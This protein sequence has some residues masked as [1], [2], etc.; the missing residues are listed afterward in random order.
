[1]RHITNIS[2][3]FLL[4]LTSTCNTGI[5]EHGT[6]KLICIS[7]PLG[8]N[9]LF[10][11]AVTS[12]I[13]NIQVCQIWTWSILN[14]ELAEF[15][16]AIIIKAHP[17]YRE[18]DHYINLRSLYHYLLIYTSLWYCSINILYAFALPAW[19]TMSNLSYSS[20]INN[21]YNTTLHYTTYRTKL[22]H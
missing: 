4:W 9:Y 10:L 14:L 18:F 2:C 16:M 15:R 20:W 8:F 22:D 7:A 3:P 19:V 6:R 12:R 21:L 5:T 13:K 17:L 11:V 1:M